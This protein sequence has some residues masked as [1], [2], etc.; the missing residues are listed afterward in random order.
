VYGSAEGGS[1]GAALVA[2]VT[3]GIWSSLADTVPLIKPESETAPR[4][5]FVPVYAKAYAKYVKM[6]DA[7]KWSFGA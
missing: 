7:L 2:G 4:P 5:E 3:A 6:Y 1:F